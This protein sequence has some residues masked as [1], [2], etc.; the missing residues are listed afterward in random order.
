[1]SSGQS[2][3][4]TQ[5]GRIRR[6]YKGKVKIENVVIIDR[7]TDEVHTATV[8]GVPESSNPEDWNAML[9]D[10]KIQ[11]RRIIS[12]DD[13]DDGYFNAGNNN[14]AGAGNDACSEKKTNWK[15]TYYQKKNLS[16]NHT[17]SYP[18]FESDSSSENDS[19]ECE[20]MEGSIGKIR[21]Q[22]EKAA[23]TKN[24]YGDIRR[25]QTGLEDR[26]STT[27]SSS[28]T[29]M[30][31]KGK[32]SAARHRELPTCSSSSSSPIGDDIHIDRFCDLDENHSTDDSA[33]NADLP[34]WRNNKVTPGRD[35][36]KVKEEKN[37]AESCD[38]QVQ[39]RKKTCFN[40]RNAKFTSKVNTY[41]YGPQLNKTEVSQDSVYIWD[42]DEGIFREPS[43]RR[44]ARSSDEVVVNNGATCSERKDELSSDKAVVNNGATFSGRNDEPIPY[45]REEYKE[46]DEHKRAMAEEWASRREQ[47][48]IQSQEAKKLRKRRRAEKLRILDVESRQKKRVEELREI[49]T[50]A[51][52]NINLKERIRVEIRN[53]LDKLEMQCTDMASLLRRLDI[54]VEG[55]SNPLPRE[56]HAAYRKALL[57]FHP[58]RASK[59]DIRQQVE[60]EEKFKLISKSK[61]KLLKTS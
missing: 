23:F 61:E 17:T 50:K 47:L 28:D 31:C 60:A 33:Q 16:K 5:L 14:K 53:K 38:I 9:K 36:F 32:A 59:T 24:M 29:E 21:E 20:V 46:T 1:M 42:E 45:G 49:M 15:E 7:E 3:P 52:E 34:W 56:V 10:S 58:D 51:E 40:Y 4:R 41:H 26:A 37:P 39:T 12:I 44:T 13:D 11:H 19:S 54:H 35:C 8:G 57:R 6:K 43:K 48:Q 22:W 18:I 55:G 27:D 2:Q 25:G 30:Y